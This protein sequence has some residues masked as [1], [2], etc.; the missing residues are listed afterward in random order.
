MARHETAHAGAR[1]LEWTRAFGRSLAAAVE[2]RRRTSRGLGRAMPILMAV[3]AAC[4]AQAGAGD[5]S[6]GAA[7]PSGSPGSTGSTASSSPGAGGEKGTGGRG[8]DACSDYA[9]LATSEEIALT[10]R[11]NA[12]AEILALEATGALLAPSE[13]YQRIG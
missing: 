11:A 5:P 3:S 12:E 7:A 13:V 8:D 6:A 9:G 2:K 1:C 4:S 10:P